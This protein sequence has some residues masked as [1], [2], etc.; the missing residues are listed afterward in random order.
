MISRGNDNL[1]SRNGEN[2]WPGGFKRPVGIETPKLIIWHLKLAW[3]IFSQLLDI[4]VVRKVHSNCLAS[5]YSWTLEML[6]NFE[7]L[8]TKQHRIVKIGDGESDGPKLPE[9]I[10]CLEMRPGVWKWL[11][12]METAYGVHKKN[13]DLGS[14]TVGVEIHKNHYM[15]AETSLKNIQPSI[16]CF[17]C[18]NGSYRP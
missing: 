1:E 3:K 18:I 17:G 15:G 10:E 11:E 5:R 7:L 13:S 14:L 4:L 6:E 8:I 9:A 16:G 2:S 12:A